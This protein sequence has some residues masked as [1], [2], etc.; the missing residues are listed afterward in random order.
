MLRIDGLMFRII[1][2]ITAAVF[3]T[4]P[5]LAQAQTAGGADDYIRG[6]ADGE[7]DAKASSMWFFA[8]FC[9]GLVGVLI[10]FLSKP[11]PSTGALIGKS[12]MYIDGYMEGYKN[13]GASMQ[14]T[15]ALY[16]WG[17]ACIITGVIYLFALVILASETD[18]GDESWG[19]PQTVLPSFSQ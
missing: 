4:V 9:F 10:A 7:R 8:G 1:A 12:Q 2:T 16:G 14:G 18:T 5:L 13:K 11:S 19:K 17:A 15:K 3:F 6:K